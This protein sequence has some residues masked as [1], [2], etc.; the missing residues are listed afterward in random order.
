MSKFKNISFRLAIYDEFIPTS[1]LKSDWTYFKFPLNYRYKKWAFNLTPSEIGIVL[2]LV[3]FCIANKSPI[4]PDM[5]QIRIRNRSVPDQNW[6]RHFKKFIENQVITDTSDPTNILT[7]ILT[8][9]TTH[10][11]DALEFPSVDKKKKTKQAVKEKPQAAEEQ[12]AQPTYDFDAV[13]NNYPRKEGRKKGE[14]IFKR[15]IKTFEDYELLKTAIE[16]YRIK[17]KDT[18]KQFIKQFGTFMNNWRDYIEREKT[19]YEEFR[20][21]LDPLLAEMAATREQREK[22]YQQRRDAWVKLR[23]QGLLDRQK[24]QEVTENAPV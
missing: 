10:P 6:I 9:S 4:V 24:Q 22:T 13:Y 21:T 17:T 16:N 19:P 5:D 8:N 12:N 3:Q 2:D 15:E 11:S 14:Q 7:N 18:E 1:S 23:E 20:E